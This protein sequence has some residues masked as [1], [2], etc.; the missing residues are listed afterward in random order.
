MR[1]AGEARIR[2]EGGPRVVLRDRSPLI[3]ELSV[4]GS[5]SKQNKD[6][7]GIKIN[8]YRPTNSVVN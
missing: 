6:G 2:R 1:K 3:R 7:K 5:I 8:L 4:I